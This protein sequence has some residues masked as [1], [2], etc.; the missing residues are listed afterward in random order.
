[1][2]LTADAALADG[3][4]EPRRWLADAEEH[5]HRAGVL[6]VAGACRSRLRAAGVMVRQRRAGTDRIPEELRA[7]GV[8]LREYDVFRLLV[9]R[10]GNKAL[11]ARLHI[12]TRTVEKHVASLLAKTGTAT[13][14]HLCDFT[15]E[16]MSAAPE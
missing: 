15:A 10:L 8:T 6:A 13:R 4:G 2:R 7:M 11:A 1:M 5:F 9:G 16:F 14:A 3:W 12:S